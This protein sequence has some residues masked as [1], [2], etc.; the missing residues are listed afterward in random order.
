MA[1]VSLELILEIAQHL[2]VQSILKLRETSKEVNELVIKY[3]HS[4]SLA[5]IASFTVSP[6]GDV[7]S[8]EMGLRRVVKHGNFEM[9]KELETRLSRA[10]KILTASTYFN[11]Q[12]PPNLGELTGPQ[13]RHLCSLL[14]RA[15]AQCDYIA[16]IAANAPYGP[17]DPRWYGKAHR[18]WWV[19]H[20]LLQGYRMLDPYTN[21]RARPA[22]HE[23]IR[24]LSN[25]DCTMIYYLLS[26]MGSGFSTA[27]LDWYDSDP[28]FYERIT[29]FEECILRHG[30][31]YAW[32]HVFGGPDWL[33]TVSPFDRVGLAELT[34]FEF[35][36]EGALPS[37]QSVLIGRFNELHKCSENS[38]QTLQ[39]VVKRLVTGVA[40][41][42]NHQ[43]QAADQDEAEGQDQEEGQ[44][45]RE[46]QAQEEDEDQDKG[47]LEQNKIDQE[48]V[49]EEQ[50]QDKQDQAE[51]DQ[52]KKEQGEKKGGGSGLRVRLVLLHRDGG[53]D[54]T[55]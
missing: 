9:V 40:D 19:D 15:F 11:L 13:Q 27:H 37:L 48:Q 12:S 22:Q 20:N 54:R 5:R 6:T 7:F 29:V 24:S 41:D 45:Q 38:L 28:S 42:G 23:Y 25:Q 2:D 47:D 55:G 21:Y 44:D 1:S 30:S 18:N 35:G 36:E 43:D 31:W 8:S 49:D 14:E 50:D 51:E 26:A 53:A 32:G 33:D 52:E 16:D 10:K 17:P 34:S 3:E 4:L 39:Q 46:T